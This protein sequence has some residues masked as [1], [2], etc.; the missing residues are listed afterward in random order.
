MPRS[1]CGVIA[2]ALAWDA[3]APTISGSPTCRVAAQIAQ[4]G[5]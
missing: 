2:G 4:L 3:F 1:G 5:N